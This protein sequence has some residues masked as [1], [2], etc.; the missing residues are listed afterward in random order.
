MSHWGKSTKAILRAGGEK[1]AQ[2]DD[3]DDDDSD[4]VDV[5]AGGKLV[6][7]KSRK[8]KQQNSIQHFM[9]IGVFS[10]NSVSE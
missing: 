5:A 10:I 1:D 9:S 4:F 8:I 2:D 3:D 7:S 6:M